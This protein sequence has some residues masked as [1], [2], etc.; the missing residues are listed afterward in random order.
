MRYIRLA[1]ALYTAVLLNCGAVFAGRVPVQG[2]MTDFNGEPV[3]GVLE[4]DFLIYETPAGGT[5]VHIHTENVSF[6]DGYYFAGIDLGGV[7]PA[8]LGDLWLAVRPSGDTEM[9]PRMR[10]LP[11]FSSL[12]SFYASSVLWDNIS[13]VPE[14]LSSEFQI[15][16]GAIADEMIA[17]VSPDKLLPGELPGHVTVTEVNWDAL[18]GVPDGFDE[19]FHIE[20]GSIG[21]EKIA[22]LSPEKLLPGELPWH[23][24]VRRVSRLEDDLDIGE[25]SIRATG[26][27]EVSISGDVRV[28][29]RVIADGFENDSGTD[30]MPDR[31]ALYTRD[32]IE[33]LTFV[34]AHTHFRDIMA[35]PAPAEGVYLVSAS[36]TFRAEEHSERVLIFRIGDNSQRVTPEHPGSYS[37]SLTGIHSLS[38]GE[39]VSLEVSVEGERTEMEIGGGNLFL[40]RVGD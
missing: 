29:G 16:D 13:G 31:S 4:V 19:G 22:G 28:S 5:P 15:D 20:D 24:S 23:V 33:P 8:E 21:D 10:I 30:L 9:I 25:R 12:H 37:L 27:D 6:D 39:T 2:R 32:F 14:H 1:A 18:T 34:T 35:A 7:D 38:E 40:L 3:S 17:G 11:S 26:S 36:L